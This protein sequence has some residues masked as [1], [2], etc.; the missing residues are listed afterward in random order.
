MQWGVEL[1]DPFSYSI[2][3]FIFFV[4]LVIILIIL[5]ARKIYVDTRPKTIKVVVKVVDRN[6]IRIEY[7]GKLN[8]LINRVNNK[9]IG[10]R[11]AYN[12]LSI[13]I[14]EF[15]YKVTRVNLLRYSLSD[16]KKLNNKVLLELITEYYEPEFSYEGTGDILASI[17]KTRKVIQEWK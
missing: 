10:T 7:I 15:I 13:I 6:R 1:V 16:F 11:N 4:L 3:G 14:R 2:L 17:D 8:D 5:V 12:E 9:K